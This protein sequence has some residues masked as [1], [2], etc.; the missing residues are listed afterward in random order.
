ME[1][2]DHRTA[3]EEEILARA[4]LLEGLRLGDIPGAR[5]TAEDPRRGRQEAGHAVEA[6]FGIPPN[7]SAGPD[8]PAAGIEL[9]TVPLEMTSNGPRIK[10]RTVISLIDFDQIWRETWASASVRKKL[11]IL[12]VFFE[13]L[14][15]RPKE[16]FPIHS[17]T[18]WQPTGPIEEQIRRD[19]ETVRDK[20]LQGRAHELSEADGRILGPCT[21]GASAASLRKQ[22]FSDVPAKSRA[23]AL[24]P[25]FTLSLYVEPRG[26]PM[27]PNRIAESAS[28]REL[29]RRFRRFVGR[30]VGDI[31]AEL[32]I[33]ES[34]AKNH[35]ATVVRRA[36]TAAS[37][38]SADELRLV[39]P[40]IRVPRVG[41]DLY[42]YEAVS[43][44]AF[45]HMSL[46]DETWSDSALLACIE[47]ML[48]IPILGETRR[49]PPEQCVVLEPVYWEPTA[50]QL[51]IIE[52]EWTMFRDL[53][54]AGR[55]DSLP[56]ESQTRAIHV[57]PHGRD[58][59]D[60]DP[61]PGGGTQ[62]KRSFW[63]NKTFVSVALRSSRV[64]KVGERA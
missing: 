14:P 30:E 6:W 64:P 4:V 55:A 5:F 59:R 47:R 44:P 46:V 15:G 3:T 27:E 56:K 35:A 49:T 21:K 48:F 36:V 28:L 31:A 8:F 54:A 12:F 17:V 25:S 2:F 62:V 50:E 13:H 38:L 26:E 43:F 22:P 45:A 37:P 40:T 24:K 20:V 29:L 1:R 39:G 63:L 10:E 60:R 52:K 16:E 7:P 34:R 57:R 19:W 53:V 42:P 51:A 58:S 18:L 9:K 32:G 11:K 23:F 33:P 61:V 41:P